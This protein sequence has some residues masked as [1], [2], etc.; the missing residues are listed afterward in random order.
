MLLPQRKFNHNTEP[1]PS[2]IVDQNAQATNNPN[3]Y[4]NASAFNIQVFAIGGGGYYAKIYDGNTPIFQRRNAAGGTDITVTVSASPQN[5]LDKFASYSYDKYSRTLTLTGAVDT[6]GGVQFTRVET[7][8]FLSDY[9]I[10]NTW[11]IVV[12]TTGGS[13]SFTNWNYYLAAINAVIDVGNTNFG[14]GTSTEPLGMGV[15][16][17]SNGPIYGVISDKAYNNFNSSTKTATAAVSG[18]SVNAPNAIVLT[19]TQGL[20]LKQWFFR[21]ANTQSDFMTKAQNAVGIAKGYAGTQW[22][23]VSQVTAYLNVRFANDLTNINI[24]PSNNYSFG[25][26]MRDSFW[27]S[28]LLPNAYEQAALTRFEVFQHATGQMPRAVRT[29]GVTI[30]YHA[31]E[32]ALLYAIRCYIDSVRRGLTYNSTVLNNAITYI[33]S[34]VVSDQYQCTSSDSGASKTWMDGFKYT[35][36]SIATYN[37]GLYCVALKCLQLLGAGNITNTQIANAIAQYQALYNSG[38]GYVTFTSDKTY[39]APDVLVGEALSLYL[40]GQSML[41]DTMVNN[42]VAAIVAKATIYG[43]PDVQTSA[44]AYLETNEFISAISKGDYQNGGS[45][46]LYEYLAY[47]AGKKHGAPGMDAAIANRKVIELNVD[48]VSHEYIRTNG[49]PLGSELPARHVYSWNAVSFVI[50]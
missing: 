12:N 4:G 3:V 23:V 1:S 47:Y 15:K 42:T 22:D 25:M 45:W 10:E 37:Q 49:S 46:F 19:P 27:Q 24:Q 11:T 44:G 36:G 43:A 14:D 20:T 17:S 7:Y 29:D 40:F 26:W 16:F 50:K 6:F 41:T 32:S 9:V 30:E 5:L 31:D 18:I 33:N 21:S 38:V 48:P 13:L 8:K 2:T 34:I 39:L 35:A 28:F